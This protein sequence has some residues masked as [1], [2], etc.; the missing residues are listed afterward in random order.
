V[1]VNPEVSFSVDFPKI[2]EV[3]LPYKRLESPVTKVG[4]QRFIF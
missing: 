2:I 3:K 1:F 4:W